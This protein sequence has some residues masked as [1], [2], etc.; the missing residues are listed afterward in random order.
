MSSFEIDPNDP[1]I[2][3][4]GLTRLKGAVHVSVEAVA[5]K[6]FLLLYP[7]KVSEMQADAGPVRLQF[8]PEGHAG[9]MWEM[10]VRG[11]DLDQYLYAFEADGKAFPDPRGKS[12]VGHEEW[13]ELASAH[14]LLKTPVRQKPFDWEGD[15]PLHI[16][17]EECI[18]YRAHVRGFTK[19]LSSGVAGK[20]TFR[21]I[22]EKIPYLKELGITTLELLPIAEFQEVMM[23]E[24]RDISPY[25]ELEPTGRLNYWGYA[26]AYAFAPKAS[27]AGKRNDPVLEL[28]KLVR[29]LHKAGIELVVEMFF[30][31]K[32]NPLYVQEAARYWVREYHIDG[33]HFAGYAPIDL[34]AKDPYLAQTKLWAPR[35]NGQGQDPRHKKRLGEYNEDFLVGVR[36]A[37]K[38]DDNQMRRFADRISSNPPNCAQLNFLA[39][40]NGF[41]M[42]DMVCYERKHNEANGEGN[43]DGSDYNF[44]WNCGE[45]GVTRRKKVLAARRR[46]L[47]NALAVLFL[48][49]G[50]PVLLAGDEFGNSQGG[51]NNAYCQDNEISW[52][53][54]RLSK[55][56]RELLDF[57]KSMIA[58]RKAH[59]V[60]H[61]PEGLRGM[62]YLAC[63][64][65]DISYHGS[66]AW[67][68]EFGV[69]SH[70]LGV[71]YCGDYGRKADKSADNTFYV[72]YNMHWEPHEFALPNLPRPYSW[73]LAMD[74]GCA[75]G[76][77]FC[78]QGEEPELETQRLLKVP[79]RTVQVLVGKPGTRNPVQPA[80]KGAAQKS[81]ARRKGRAAGLGGRAAAGKREEGA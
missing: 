24:H 65:P 74:T 17:Y 47:H 70:E 55:A 45:E 75:K 64:H 62:D 2:Y 33:I 6:C 10:T 7:R 52:L 77:G 67:V 46:Q 31:G 42:M 37:L 15:R 4:V 57:T 11:K 9:D 19:H 26:R 36:C 59:P 71:L 63:G 35:W 68:P 50:T 39:G 12:F 56:N 66:R 14:T 54:W 34:V 29:T 49:Q 8:P 16:P 13:G 69:S 32:E 38:G 21:G 20:G 5:E 40:T 23:P 80:I 72:A 61:Q 73:H 58:F 30:S 79:P 53:N 81:A 76:D 48:S 41:T 44:S 43:R 28:K 22:V 1:G 51:N 60:F 27:Y 18:V 25:G 3:P 78:P